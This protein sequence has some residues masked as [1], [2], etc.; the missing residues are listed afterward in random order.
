MDDGS[1]DE[2]PELLERLN[3][4]HPAV[5]V[6]HLSRNFG[7]Q[8]ALSAGLEWSS[9][10]AVVLM[11]GDGQDPPELIPRFLELWAEGN[12]VVF[13]VRRGRKEARWK[14]GAYFLF[15]RLLRAMGEVEIPMDAGDFCLMDR[16]VV[17]AMQAMPETG[18]VD[19]PSNARRETA[20][21]ISVMLSPF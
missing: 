15:Y 9:G 6:L 21:E 14:R 1:S 4:S 10:E 11:D 8:N 7:H 13:G 16:K 2:S 19:R 12:D 17:A 3:A 18:T 20:E 5:K